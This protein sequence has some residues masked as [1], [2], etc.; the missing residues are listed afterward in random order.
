MS[1]FYE[2]YKINFQYREKLLSSLSNIG[3]SREFSKGDIIESSKTR[4]EYIYFIKSGIVR[5]YFL[6]IEG[7]EKTVLMLKTGDIFGEITMIQGDSDMVISEAY[8][9]SVVN[10]ISKREFFDFLSDNPSMNHQI[11]THLTSKIRI[12][13]FQLYDNNYFNMK[14]KLFNLL[15][16]LS[17][18]QG[19]QLGSDRII[20]I[21]LTHE[22]LASMIGSTRSTV[23]RLLNE[24][25][26]ENYIKRTRRGIV[27]KIERF[28]EYVD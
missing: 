18:Q 27:I 23:T 13:M 14:T 8:T 7:R 19:K 24:L 6:D 21:E 5:Q 2:N 9:G 1:G 20:D 11:M 3:I 26:T 12:L 16:R 28:F 4:L 15:Y 22:I 25:E 17:I 10:V